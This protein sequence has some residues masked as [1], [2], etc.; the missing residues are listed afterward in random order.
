[1]IQKQSN[2]MALAFN[3]QFGNIPWTDADRLGVVDAA[4][5]GDIFQRKRLDRG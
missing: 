1:M 5:V 2:S 4:N 3:D